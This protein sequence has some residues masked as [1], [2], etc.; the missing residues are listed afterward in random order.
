VGEQFPITPDPVVPPVPVAP[1]ELLP[2][3]VPEPVVCPAPVLCPPLDPELV[4][5]FPPFEHA[6]EISAA[7]KNETWIRVIDTLRG[8]G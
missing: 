7:A 2:A 3:P 4:V 6:T 8:L 1:E 5:P